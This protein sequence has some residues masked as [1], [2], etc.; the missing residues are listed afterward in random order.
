[1]R[2]PTTCRFVSTILSLLSLSCAGAHRQARNAPG[3]ATRPAV[4]DEP[5]GHT[6]LGVYASTSETGG[7]SGTV[8][9]LERNWNDQLRYRMRFYSD[10]SLGDDGIEQDEPSGDCLI[11]GATLYLPQAH[12][13]MREGKPILLATLTRYTRVTI[14]GHTVLLRDD[15]LRA[16][17]A[18][19]E[20]YDYGILVR[21]GG[22]PEWLADLRSVKHPSIKTLYADPSKPWD[23]PFVHGPNLR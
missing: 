13:F 2:Y 14:N 12:G 8:L 5:A 22:P 21:V 17:R 16:Y 15:A 1:V 4:A 20:L 9:A 6:W 3:P 7:F 11:E 18:K 23:D 19:N 10:V